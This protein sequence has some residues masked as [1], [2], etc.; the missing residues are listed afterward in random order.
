MSIYE[1]R[2]TLADAMKELFARWND[3][4]AV[5]HDAQSKEFEKTY[6]E[7]LEPTVRNSLKALE[8][9]H[10]TLQTLNSDCQ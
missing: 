10:I 9:L 8:Q 1:S 7:P 2:G 6:L 5:W 4:Q 3:V